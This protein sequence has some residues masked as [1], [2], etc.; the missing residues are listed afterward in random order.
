MLRRIEQNDP[1]LAE[2]L[3]MLDEQRPGIIV[4][5]IVDAL[6]PRLA[7]AMDA[8]AANPALPTRPPPPG[9]GPRPEFDGPEG[10]RRPP[11]G[12]PPPHRPPG[13]PPY[14]PISKE[15]KDRLDE[16]DRQMNEVLG[17]LRALDKDPGGAGDARL[18]LEEELREIVAA[19]FEARGEI[20]R[21]ELQWLEREIQRIRGE[22][23]H[24]AAERE[25]I[26]ERRMQHLL[27]RGAP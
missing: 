12:E 18:P 6:M 5:I 23:E 19:Q 8:A 16:L 4:D 15:L 17:E 7:N 10:G 1:K 13:P 14:A 20:R 25:K 2:R 27:R 9:H 26:I 11:P 3:R 21:T 24:R 22:L